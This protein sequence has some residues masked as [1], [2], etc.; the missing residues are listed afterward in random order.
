VT[1]PAS[2][3]AL[4]FGIL[5]YAWW[6]FITPIYFA[7]LHDV[8]AV[9]LLAHRVV[10]GVPLLAVILSL[11]RQ[12]P[13]VRESLRD[14]ETLR[15]LVITTL[16]ITVNWFT[17]VLAVITQRTMEASL[18]YYANPL[19]NVALGMIALGERLR[20]GQWIALAI[21]AAGVA[22]LA[23]AERSAPWIS[24]VLALSF[25]FYGLLRKRVRA[26]ALPGLMVETGL[27]FPIAAGALVVIAVQGT[28][29]RPAA[30]PFLLPLAG[31]V[32][33]VPLAF[34]VVAARGLRLST[35]GFLQYIAPTG[36]FLTAVLLGEPFTRVRAITFVLIWIA[37]TIYSIDLVRAMRKA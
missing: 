33:I 28:G 25:A 36:Q 10:W 24:L 14:A 18:G 4:I 20:P 26:A 13:G 30:A 32:T 9:E 2:Q 19:V 27:M 1:A 12:W 3:R 34:F 7:I 5:A 31:A 37:L 8:S 23:I 22:Q 15:I 17:F 29:P 16:L 21:A 35:V 11:R 6:G